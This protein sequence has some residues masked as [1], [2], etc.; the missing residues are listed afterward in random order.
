[1]A[2]SSGQRVTGPLLL[3]TATGYALGAAVDA[4]Q[5]LQEIFSLK[6]RPQDMPLLLLVSGPEMALSCLAPE[7]HE[8]VLY[9]ALAL[10]PS[11]LTLVVPAAEGLPREVLSNLGEVAVRWDPDPD[12]QDFL[13][14]AGV[15]FSGTSANLSGKAPQADPKDICRQLGVEL[16]MAGAGRERP[17]RRPSTMARLAGEG[18][19]ILRAGQVP[20]DNLGGLSPGRATL[21]ADS[22]RVSDTGGEVEIA[23]PGQ[24]G[25]TVRESQQGTLLPLSRTVG[26][27][28]ILYHLQRSGFSSCTLGAPWAAALEDLDPD[29]SLLRGLQIT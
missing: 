17:L 20:T 5:A 29:D 27:R 9:V 15:P 11:S 6:K 1:M 13:E 21:S 19:A 10:W 2:E 24:D 26:L 28:G 7:V 18:W 23:L 3:P 14:M 8:R 12:L 22:L 16:P 25:G 4:P